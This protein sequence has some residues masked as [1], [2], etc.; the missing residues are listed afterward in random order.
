[1][2]FPLVLITEII[3]PYRIPLFNALASSPDV[4]LHVMFL[5]ETDPTLRQWQIYTK[6]IQFSYEVLPSWRVRLG[7]YNILL[8]R[9]VSSSLR[10]AAPRLI[11]FGG[12]SYAAS[13]QA[14][15]WARAHSVP[16]CLWTESNLQDTRKGHLLV[17]LLKRSFLRR[18]SSFAVAGE[19]SR[20]Y[21]RAH[22]IE[23][24][25]IFTTPNAVDN[26]LFAGAANLARLDATECRKRLGLPAR[27]FLFVGRLV[28]EKGVF[29][30]LA[31]YATLEPSLR[32]QIALVL[33]GDGRSRPELEKQAAAISPGTVIF[34]GFAQRN[35]LAEYYA[36]AE[37]LVMPTHSDPWGLVVNEAMSCGLPVI[38]SD[39]AG[40]AR[41]LVEHDWNG[42][43][44][45]AKNVPSLAN[46]MEEL[47]RD[48]RKRTEMA[49]NSLVRI[50]MYT[51]TRWAAG[52]HE[53]IARYS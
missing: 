15:G 44:A 52:I 36:L 37:T 3:S 50:A 38:L 24:D 30:L 23:N 25:R 46:A 41:D 47:A 53:M 31:A 42:K 11:V 18:C 33:A 12:Y 35:A 6:E 49:A 40:C 29:D 26:D 4:D 39:V 8:N 22:G 9:R 1:M 16:F 2:R 43:L 10:K 34:A 5:A 7:G 13:W 21:L 32:E 19:S 51:P 27:Y 14:L 20:A 28:P 17:E 48:S 45:P